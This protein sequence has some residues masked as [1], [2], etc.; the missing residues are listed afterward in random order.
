M[1]KYGKIPIVA[2]GDCQ[3]PFDVVHL[4][5]IGLWQVRFSRGAK[6]ITKEI[7]ALTMVDR[8]TT[9]PKIVYAKSNDSEYLSKIFDKQWLC[10]YPGP[11]RVV[12]DNSGKF[13]GFEFQEMC[14][15]FGIK[16]VPT[17][18]KN[19]QSNLTAKR[20]HLTIGDMLRTMT[21]SGENW[22]NEMETA[23][24]SAT[25]AIRSTV[26]TMSGYTPAQMVFSKNMIMQLAVTANWEKVK[27][28][29]RQAAKTANERKN[30]LRVKYE[31]SKGDKILILVKNNGVASKLASPTEGPHEILKVYGNGTI[32]IK[33]GSYDKVINIR[34]VKPFHV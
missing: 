19:P 6:V 29:K 32:K 3:A 15:N 18:V 13:T 26:S 30:C 27:Q 28:L 17:T 12:H 21:F 5:M 24:Q 14:S 33:R 9:W 25:L 8:A 16:T 7:K 20:M 4:D 31:Y 1:K 23:L 22:E 34:M 10:R 11:K 2:E